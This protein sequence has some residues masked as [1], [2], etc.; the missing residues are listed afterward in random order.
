VCLCAGL[1]LEYAGL[2]WLARIADQVLG[3]R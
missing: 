3:R 1:V 2:S